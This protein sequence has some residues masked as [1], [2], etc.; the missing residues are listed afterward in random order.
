MK[1]LKDN[2]SEIASSDYWLSRRSIRNFTGEP[3][4]LDL[5]YS[6]IEKAAKSP[7]TGGMQLYSIIITTDASRRSQ[8]AQFH[9]N[10]PASTGCPVMLTV[11]ADF[12]RFDKWCRQRNA[13]PGF[14]N[15]ES[16]IA[17]M[18]DA[19]IFGQQLCTLLETE[20]LGTCYL[21]TTTYT[22]SKIGSLLELPP[23]TVPIVTIA[24]GWPAS[25]GVDA[26]RLPTDAII[27]HEKYTDYSPQR[28]DEIYAEKESLPANRSF[29]EENKLPSLAH[30]FT[31]IRYPKNNA[32][33]FSRDFYEYIEKQGFRFPVN[34]D[35]N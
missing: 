9:F 1:P 35:K 8:L 22:A 33:I 19:T 17:A 3:V 16:F 6:C 15:F 5:I 29:V 32:E 25:A 2:Y 12:N 13:T 23:L 30:V 26:E 27:H 7:T 18:L 20:G 4:S 28:I 34:N 31:D 14:D 24:V 21:G 10:Q 11:V